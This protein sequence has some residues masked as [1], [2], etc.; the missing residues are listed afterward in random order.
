MKKKGRLEAQYIRTLL[1]ICPSWVLDL[2]ESIHAFMT[3]WYLFFS[4]Q[5]EN[6]PSMFHQNWKVR[7][8][9]IPVSAWLTGISFRGCPDGLEPTTFSARPQDACKARTTSRV[10]NIRNPL[11]LS[12]FPQI[13]IFILRLFCGYLR[14]D[15]F[16][17][18]KSLKIWDESL[19]NS[20]AIIKWQTFFKSDAKVDK[21]IK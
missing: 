13:L 7:E 19:L 4:E 6:V 12:A 11:Y 3:I 5:F 1:N 2:L 16:C 20:S 14:K 21:V 8:L 10:S 9:K 15:R 17:F 18:N